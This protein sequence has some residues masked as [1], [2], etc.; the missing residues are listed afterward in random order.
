MIICVSRI[1]EFFSFSFNNLDNIVRMDEIDEEWIKN[2]K[3]ESDRE[4]FNCNGKRYTFFFFFKRVIIID[5]LKGE[6]NINT[7][8]E[9]LA[10]MSC[11]SQL[12]FFLRR[13]E[14][15]EKKNRI[16]KTI[17][18]CTETEIISMEDKLGK[19]KKIYFIAS[20]REKIR[21]P[22]LRISCSLAGGTREI[23]GNE[24]IVLFIVKY[25]SKYYKFY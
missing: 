24:K 25:L 23:K 7:L 18:K 5:N 9:I 12:L 3:K 17:Y 1:G 6:I 19:K 15:E 2:F 13:K 22:F 20:H 8:F 21:F 10:T 11:L 4:R 14:R 16:Q